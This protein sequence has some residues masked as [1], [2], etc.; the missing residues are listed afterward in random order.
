MDK[1]VEEPRA[2]ELLYFHSKTKW[3]KVPALPL[4]LTSRRDAV[5]SSNH[6]TTGC[7]ARM[8]LPI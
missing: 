8:S 7:C 4:V 1:L 3:T 2:K 5:C 6:G